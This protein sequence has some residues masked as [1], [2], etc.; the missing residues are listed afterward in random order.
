ML[1][2][3]YHLYILAGVH[4]Y[5]Q[6]DFYLYQKSSVLLFTKQGSI[7]KPELTYEKNDLDQKQIT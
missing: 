3:V 6:V 5:K 7:W 4:F 2:S 1:F